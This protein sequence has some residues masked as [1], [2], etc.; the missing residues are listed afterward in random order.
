MVAEAELQTAMSRLRD[1][2]VLEAQLKLAHQLVVT[3]QHNVFVATVRA[4]HGVASR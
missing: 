3:S 2:E 1:A 4:T